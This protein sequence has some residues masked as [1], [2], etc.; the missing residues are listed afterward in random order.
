MQVFQT[1]RLRVASVVLLASLSPLVVVAQVLDLDPMSDDGAPHAIR[2]ESAFAQIPESAKMALERAYGAVEMAQ[3][4][5]EQLTASLN[6]AQAR[7]AELEGELQAARAKLRARASV[8][9]VETQGGSLTLR[10]APAGE[11]AGS[12]T[13]N[14]AVFVGD[15]ERVGERQWCRVEQIGQPSAEGWAADEFLRRIPV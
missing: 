3:G 12:I 4:L 2:Q 5:N 8:A 13:N 9:T 14:A 15:C 7:M 6:H 10:A 1:L 11:R